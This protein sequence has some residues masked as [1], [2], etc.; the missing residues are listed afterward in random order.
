MGA[1]PNVYTGYQS[2]G[3]PAAQ[4]RFNEAWGVTL[5]DKPGLTVTEAVD[6][7]HAGTLKGST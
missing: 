7:M 3:D 5:P 1:L 4:S 6:A 2:V